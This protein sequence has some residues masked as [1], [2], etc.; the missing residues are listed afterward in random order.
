VDKVVLNKYWGFGVPDYSQLKAVSLCPAFITDTAERF[1]CYLLHSVIYIYIYI[2]IYVY[3]YIIYFFIRYKCYLFWFCIQAKLAYGTSSMWSMVKMATE[4][5][6]FKSATN[7]N[8]AY[9]SSEAYIIDR[10]LVH[11]PYGM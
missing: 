1:C 5:A 9:S 6:I 10:R 2:Y 7:P 3:I 4:M 8:N 11:I